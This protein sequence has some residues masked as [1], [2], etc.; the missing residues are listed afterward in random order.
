MEQ[1]RKYWVEANPVIL[2]Y[3]LNIRTIIVIIVDNFR[4]GCGLVSCIQG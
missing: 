4:P 2:K 3:Q 1:S